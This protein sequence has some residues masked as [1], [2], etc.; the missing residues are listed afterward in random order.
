MIESEITDR[1][2]PKS[3]IGMLRNPHSG[4]EPSG[5]TYKKLC[6]GK[7]PERWCEQKRRYGFEED[8]AGG[9]VPSAKSDGGF[10]SGPKDRNSLQAELSVHVGNSSLD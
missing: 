6:S 3:A 10:L 4:E 5:L 2:R 9:T 8:S 7:F 1:L